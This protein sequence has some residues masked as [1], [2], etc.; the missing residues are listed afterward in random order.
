[1]A[2]SNM[3]SPVILRENSGKI[4]GFDRTVIEESGSDNDNSIGFTDLDFANVARD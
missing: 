3:S 4:G 1:M 2:I